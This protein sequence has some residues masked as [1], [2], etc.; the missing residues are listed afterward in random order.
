MC[1][2]FNRE[3]SSARTDVEETLGARQPKLANGATP[4]AAIQPAAQQMIEPVVSLRDRIEHAGDTLGSLDVE[5]L[6]R[7]SREQTAVAR[8]RA[9]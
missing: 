8:N 4:P 1:G 7:L 3:I 2:G 9:R 6:T 5:T